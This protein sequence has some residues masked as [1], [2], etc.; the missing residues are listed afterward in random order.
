[1]KEN[2]EKRKWYF[3]IAVALIVGARSDILQL[4]HYQRLEMQKTHYIISLIL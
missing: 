2:K 4:M 3:L 1:M